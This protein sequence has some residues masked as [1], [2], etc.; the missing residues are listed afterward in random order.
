MDARTFSPTASAMALGPTQPTIPRLLEALTVTEIGLG[1]KRRELECMELHCQLSASSIIK[2][3]NS[4]LTLLF[5]P[6]SQIYRMKRATCFGVLTSDL[7]HNNTKTKS[8]FLLPVSNHVPRCEDPR[9]KGDSTRAVR[10]VSRHFE[11][12]ENRYSDLDVS[13]QPVRGDLTAPSWRV[14]LPWG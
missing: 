3:A 1:G 7:A 2:R 6:V 10:K 13:W 4:S 14:T 11:Y 8:C 9:G 12:L 5:I